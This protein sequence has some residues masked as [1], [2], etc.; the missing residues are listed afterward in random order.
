[1]EKKKKILITLNKYHN[2]GYWLAIDTSTKYYHNDRFGR[3]ASVM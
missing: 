2:I 1:M 3:K